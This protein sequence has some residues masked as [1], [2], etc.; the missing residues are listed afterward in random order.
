M[1]MEFNDHIS[2]P[3]KGNGNFQ[4]FFQ[5]ET[6]PSLRSLNLMLV[7]VDLMIYI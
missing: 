4:T 1:E 5:V 6:R 7:L 2:T 3:L